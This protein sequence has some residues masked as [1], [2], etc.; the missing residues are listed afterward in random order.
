MSYLYLRGVN[1]FLTIGDIESQ[2]VF[3][4]INDTRERH[5]Q[6][7]NLYRILNKEHDVIT[8]IIICLINIILMR[9]LRYLTTQSSVIKHITKY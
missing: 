4:R 7:Y 6:K 8:P 3:M 1:I 9:L 2:M 5:V